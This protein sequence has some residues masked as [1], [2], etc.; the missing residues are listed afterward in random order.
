MNDFPQQ[1]CY[2]E[3]K[4]LYKSINKYP[5]N[6]VLVPNQQLANVVDLQYHGYHQDTR[7][8]STDVT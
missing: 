7:L 5:I 6:Q 1:A 2:H 4:Y 8:D 3:S